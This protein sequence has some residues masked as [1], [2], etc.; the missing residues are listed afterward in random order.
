MEDALQERP[1][2]FGERVANLRAEKRLSASETARRAGISRQ[3]LYRIENGTTA[4]PHRDVIMRVAEALEVDAF[5]LLKPDSSSA[6]ETTFQVLWQHVSAISDEDW[7]LMEEL[8]TRVT[9][10]LRAP[11]RL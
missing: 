11:R 1:C 8:E 10:S 6:R 9:R 7:Q 4:S 5:R 3:T 2:A